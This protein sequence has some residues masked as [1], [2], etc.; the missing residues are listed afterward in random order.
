MAVFM[1]SP[2]WISPAVAQDVVAALPGN[3]AS[4]AQDK[5]ANPLLAGQHY[6]SEDE[7][8]H[9]REDPEYHLQFRK[10]LENTMNNSTDVFVAGSEMNEGART[11]MKAE[12]EKRIGPGHNDLKERLIPTWPP[13]KIINIMHSIPTVSAYLSSLRIQVAAVSLQVMDI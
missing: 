2:T 13:G 4:S 11:M 5:M 8:K 6:F 3:A 7:K 9:F 12:M 1:R 10:K